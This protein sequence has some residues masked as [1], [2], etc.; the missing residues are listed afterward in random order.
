[1]KH[2]VSTMMTTINMFQEVGYGQK[3]N[4]DH[5]FAIIETIAERKKIG[6]DIRQESKR[7]QKKEEKLSSE[8][9]KGGVLDTKFSSDGVYIA[10]ITEEF[11]TVIWVWETEQLTLHSCIMLKK[12]V[13]SI[14]WHSSLP[15]LV[16]SASTQT[17]YMWS[18]THCSCV[19]VPDEELYVVDNVKWNQ[20][21]GALCLSGRK[22]RSSAPGAKKSFR[23][24][25]SVCFVDANEMSF[26]DHENSR[27]AE[28]C[29]ANTTELGDEGDVGRTSS[30]EKSITTLT[31]SEGDC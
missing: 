22:Q 28:Q 18:I 5:R 19:E 9:A 1:M 7:K 6:L 10:T 2:D 4:V 25:Y 16:A 14:D 20:D 21:G 26:L 8:E 17:M 27:N 24:C 3:E 11:P 15:I 31:D 30:N 29:R 13:R 23:Y 12:A